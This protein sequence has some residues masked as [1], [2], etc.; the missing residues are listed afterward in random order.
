MQ[1]VTGQYAQYLHGRLNRRGRLWQGRFYS[2]VLDAHHFL[3]AL[4]Y[5]D[6]NAVRAGMVAGMVKRAADYAWS[7]AAAQLGLV[8]TGGW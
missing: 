7:S 6:L 8:A 3:T 4:A 1:H 2:C 5:V